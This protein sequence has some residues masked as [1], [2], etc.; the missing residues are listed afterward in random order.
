MKEK[1][2]KNIA[3]GKIN[4]IFEQVEKEDDQ[5]SEERQ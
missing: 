1:Y 4:I 5:E 2:D 3:D